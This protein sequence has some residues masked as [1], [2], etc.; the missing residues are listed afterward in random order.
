ME[1]QYEKRKIYFKN[2][3]CDI[4]NKFIQIFEKTT[5]VQNEICKPPAPTI[6]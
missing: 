1:K 6:D 2:N 3:S 4:K 5:N